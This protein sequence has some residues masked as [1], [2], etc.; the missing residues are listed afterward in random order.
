MDTEYRILSIRQPWAGL[1]VTGA[2]TIE[3]RKWSTRYRG[4]LLIHAGLKSLVG[5]RVEAYCKARGVDLAKLPDSGNFHG[6][7][8]GICDL[9]DCVEESKNKWFNG[10]YGFVLENARPLRFISCPGQLR[11]YKPDAALLQRLHPRAARG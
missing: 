11:L 6:G 10:P 7:I 9:T 2:K 8:I 5:D 1:I 4:P 3:N